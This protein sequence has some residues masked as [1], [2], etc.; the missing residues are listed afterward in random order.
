[1]PIR[2][3]IPMRKIPFSKALERY[4]REVSILKRSYASEKFRLE[5]LARSFLGQKTVDEITSVD[6]A[7]YRDARLASVNGKTGNLISTSTVRLEMSLMS[8]VFDICRIEWGYCKANPTSNVKKPKPAPA[9][10]RRLSGREERLILRY[11]HAHPNPELQT[12]VI[13]AIESAMRQGEILNLKWE[14]INLR[15]RV[16]H[17]PETKNGTARDVPLSLRARDALMRLGVQSKGK[18]FNYT[19]AGIKSTWRYMM[20]SLC[21]E[22]LHFHDL[23]HEAIS[24]LAEMGSFDLLEISAISGHKSLTMLKRYTHHQTSKLVKK[25][26]GPVNRQQQ[27]LSQLLVPYPAAVRKEAEAFVVRILDFDNLQVIARSVEEASALASDALLRRLCTMRMQGQKPPL[28]DQYLEAIPEEN[29]L[30]V[31]PVVLDEVDE[32]IPVAT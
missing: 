23:R 20:A 19:S 2:L 13:L 9:R 22:D 28:P 12:I 14:H 7:T 21:I 32:Q 8:S 18:V 3:Q 27:A 11:T 15:T 5:Q 1:M 29:L 10:I 6:I 26:D 25:I 17:L 24:R 16:A 30:M 4:R 31:V